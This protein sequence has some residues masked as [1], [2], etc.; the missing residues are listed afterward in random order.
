[1]DTIAPITMLHNKLVIY[2]DSSV[3]S[4]WLDWQSRSANSHAVLITAVTSISTLQQ[5]VHTVWLK[6][7]PL[8]QKCQH[9]ELPAP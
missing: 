9:N 2:I 1:M 6:M 5:N 8:R 4:Q 7:K 3:T